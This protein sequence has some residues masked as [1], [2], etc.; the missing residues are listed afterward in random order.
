MKIYSE[1]EPAG[2]ILA[3]IQKRSRLSILKYLAVLRVSI[4]NNLAYIMEVF[5]RA[6][7]LVVLVFVLT[8]LW[9]TTFA[10]RG[11]RILSGFTITDM[12]WYLVATNF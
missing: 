4:L 3:R 11:T 12:V 2:E 5:F 7:F 10:L 6:L 1:R 9:K 8:Q